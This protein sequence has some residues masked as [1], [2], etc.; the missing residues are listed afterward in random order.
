MQLVFSTSLQL[1]GDVLTL[2]EDGSK[3]KVLEVTGDEREQGTYKLKCGVWHSVPEFLEVAKGLAHPFDRCELM[4]EQLRLALANKLTCS[5][6][7]VARRRLNVIKSLWQLRK[8]L[9][10]KEADSK[11]KLPQSIKGV[12]KDRQVHLLQHLLE[13]IGYKDREA[14]VRNLWYGA[15]I[16]STVDSSAEFPGKH[17]P[18]VASAAELRARAVGRIIYTF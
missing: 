16:T 12:L 14:V 7:E 11:A 15:D 4:P 10:H 8:E 2:E 18:A 17:V 5:P 6:G 9:A 1:P 3:A 13:R